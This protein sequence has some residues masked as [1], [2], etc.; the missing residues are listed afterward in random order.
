MR[1]NSQIGQQ[2][3]LFGPEVAPVN[4]LASQETCAEKKTTGTCGL[5]SSGLLA[6]ANLQQSLEN[7]LHKRLGDYGSIEYALTWHHWDMPSGLPILRR[8]ALAHRTSGKGCGGWP[9]PST[10]D[11]KEG[12]TGGRIRNGKISTDTLDVTAQIVGWYIP[13]ASDHKGGRH[14]KKNGTPGG[15]LVWQAAGMESNEEYRLNPLFSLWLMG[16]PKE[17][18]C[19]EAQ[20]TPLYRK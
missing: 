16:Y 15:T 7:R 19:L 4:H 2:L 1:L 11:H 3:P 8:R 18:A 14:S 9:T 17:W 10:R 6:S 12:Y 5:T 13:R 20:A